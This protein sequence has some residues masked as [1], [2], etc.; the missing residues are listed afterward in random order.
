MGTLTNELLGDPR[1]GRVVIITSVTTDNPA[2]GTFDLAKADAVLA[3]Q[4]VGEDPPGGLSLADL[5]MEAGRGDFA[6]TFDLAMVDPYH[7][8]DSSM[9]CL[10]LA[11]G[12]LRPSGVLLVHDCLPPLEYTAPE[13]IT[14]N[15]CGTTFAAF[16]DLCTANG[17]CWFTVAADMGI[18]VAVKGTDPVD[19]RLPEDAWTQQTHEA[20][21]QRYRADPCSLMQAVDGA[22]ARTALELALVGAQAAHVRVAFDGWEDLD[23]R[24]HRSSDRSWQR[25]LHENQ[26]MRDEV[27][28]LTAQIRALESELDALQARNYDLQAQVTDLYAHI[29]EM[30]RPTWQA[31][32]LLRSAPKAARTRME[33]RWRPDRP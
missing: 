2:L 13:F 19:V 20:Y 25:L 29:T 11:L 23:E 24:T 5:A 18:G 32:A 1:F 6:G 26:A 12:M 4:Y 17:L 3:L 28:H 15:W 21:M 14:G 10:E 33:R 16:R 30:R 7:T 27:D 31:R 8:Y 22:D 9:Q